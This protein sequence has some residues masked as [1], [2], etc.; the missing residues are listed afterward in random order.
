MSGSWAVLRVDNIVFKPFKI[1]S[2]SFSFVKKC[3]ISFT[4]GRFV[5]LNIEMKC[6]DA[7]QYL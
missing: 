5:I 3:P 2:D 6:N 4:I 1:K 7:K